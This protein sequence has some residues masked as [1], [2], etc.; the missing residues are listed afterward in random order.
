[1]HYDR[2]IAT[3]FNDPFHL[4]VSTYGGGGID[5]TIL[6][7]NKTTTSINKCSM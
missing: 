7:F 1:L 6:G 5:G 4:L 2:V 3:M